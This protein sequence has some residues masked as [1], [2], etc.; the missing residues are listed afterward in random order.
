MTRFHFDPMRKSE[1]HQRKKNWQL[2]NAI[3]RKAHIAVGNA[4]R[5]GLM[6]KP[7]NC[8]KCGGPGKIEGHHSDYTTPL[9]VDWLCVPCHKEAHRIERLERK[10]LDSPM[11][12]P[13]IST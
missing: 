8:G 7:A 9:D 4:V 11:Q 5:D 3:K 1:N 6:V 12:T 2:R 10:C 13:L